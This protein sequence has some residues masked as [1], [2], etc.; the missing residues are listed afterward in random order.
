[1]Q[2]R[3]KL[4]NLIFLLTLLTGFV[5]FNAGLT[6]VSA[7]L[8][9]QTIT[10]QEADR[11]FKQGVEQYKAKQLQSAITS[12]QQALTAY[13]TLKDRPREATTL[14]NLSAV[15]IELA[16]Y[17]QAIANLQQYLNLTRELRNR[18]GEQAVLVA[19]ALKP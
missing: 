3:Y 12:W 7:S 18:Q 9:A 11:I 8:I 15:Y 13:R 5:P 16:D 2:K 19:I 6:T 10:R 4:I 17:P 1:M 14:K